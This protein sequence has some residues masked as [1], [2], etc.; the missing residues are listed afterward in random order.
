MIVLY[1]LVLIGAG[2]V[3]WKRRQQGGGATGWRWFF[4]WAFAGA[5]F[6]FSLI[7]GFSIGLVL[8]P[9]AA[10]AVFWLAATAP[11]AREALGFALGS[12]VLLSGIFLLI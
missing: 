3:M 4:A 8:L 12:A 9:L 2:L 6:T 7:T 1:A 10:L 5:L 11:H